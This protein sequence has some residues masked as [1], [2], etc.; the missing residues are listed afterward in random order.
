MRRTA[1]GD[2]LIAFDDLLKAD[3]AGMSVGAVGR[4]VG[5]LPWR[6]GSQAGP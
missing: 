2:A 6:A 1:L 3:P 5:L 4:G